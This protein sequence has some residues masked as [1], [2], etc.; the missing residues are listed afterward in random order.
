MALKRVFRRISPDP[1][2]SFPRIARMHR[3]REAGVLSQHCDVVGNLRFEV[4]PMHHQSPDGQ[5]IFIIELNSTD[6]RYH[7]RFPEMVLGMK[8][9]DEVL[10]RMLK[11]R[12]TPH[13]PIGKKRESTK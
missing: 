12:P 13:V 11:T 5:G 6:M 9:R 4:C 7:Y 1:A 8:K 10:K 2:Q 3:N